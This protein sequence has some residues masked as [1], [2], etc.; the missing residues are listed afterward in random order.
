MIALRE[1]NFSLQLEATLDGLGIPV[2]IGGDFNTVRRAEEKV[3]GPACVTEM[4]DFEN[5]IQGRNLIVLPLE[6]SSYTW[7]KGGSSSTA[8]RLD[9]FLL[10]TEF[11]AWFPCLVQS[12]FPRSLSDHYPVLLGENKVGC[13]PRPFKWFSHWSED[14]SYAEMINK[15]CA[16]CKNK[17]VGILMK[18]VKVASKEWVS[19]VHSN[20]PENVAG[21]ENRIEKLEQTALVARDNSEIL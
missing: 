20:D 21:L 11:L 6:G 9:R 1:E 16:E 15:V 7:F 14:R 12:F 2:V 13:G 8:C 5:F 19:K 4:A 10:S 18:K 17:G 3:G